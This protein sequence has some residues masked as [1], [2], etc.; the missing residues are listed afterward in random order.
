[1]AKK[2]TAWY[3]RRYVERFHFSLVPIEPG[4]KFPKVDDWGKN[5]LSDPDQA[6]QFYDD[7]AD[8]NIGVALGPSNL[9]S[10][11]VDHLESFK[12]ICECCGVDFDAL[13]A[14]TPTVRGRNPRLMF[15]V[16]AGANLPYRKLNWPNERDPDGSIHKDLIELAQQAKKD[17]DQKLEAQLREEAKQYAIYTVFELRSATDGKQRQDVLPP[18]IHPDTGNPYEW[19]TQPMDDW[20]EPPAWLL[21]IWTDW[22]KFKPQLRAMCPWSVEPEIPERKVKP[23]S[24]MPTTGV[25]DAFNRAN[26]LEAMLPHYGYKQIGKRWLSPHS[27]TSI[28]GVV[29]F[30]GGETCWIHHASDPLCSDE[31]GHPVGP[32]DLFCFYEHNGDVRRAVKAAADE[33]GMKP[34]AIVHNAQPLSTLTVDQETGEIILPP[35]GQPSYAE[36][37]A[38]AIPSRDTM[39]PLPWANDKGKPLKHIDNLREICNRL[40]VTIRYN[41]IK[42]EQELI[43]PGEKFSIDNEANAALA[44]LTSECS[45]FQFPTDKLGD[46]ITYLADQ[47]Q[48]NPV[49]RWITSKPWDGQDR[50]L[51]LLD[52][53]VA[54]DQDVNP[55]AKQLKE[56]LIL[57]WA[58]SAVAAAFSTNGISAPGILVFQGP[59]Y[60]GKTKWFKTLVPKDLD[61]LKDGMLLRPDDKDSVKQ[62]V[63]F[64]MVE[65]G[66]LDSTFRKSDIAALKAFI[67]NDRDILRRAYDRR[68]SQFA[69]RTVFFGSVNPREYLH[70][71]TGNRRYW[72]IECE[73]LDY[74]HTI[75]M[76]QFWAQIYQLWSDGEG[77]Y[78]TPEEMHLLNSHNDTFM[79][80][81]P[82]EERLDQSLDWDAPTLSWRWA[83][84]TILALECGIDRPSK[85]DLVAVSGYIRKRN[86]GQHKR[87][88]GKN[89]LFVPPSRRHH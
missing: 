5:A 34:P 80:L 74:N 73:S 58:I 88:N 24:N 36:D 76:Q 11:D 56:T 32:F 79:T 69:R 65:L 38:L 44:W 20:P 17:G 18:S 70:D 25:I 68:E 1:M 59:Q 85:S 28:P 71:P 51:Q 43:I 37:R 81:D 35:P 83:Q 40:G 7:H 33:L 50:I 77:F 49:T 27:S 31:S 61:L 46:F 52:T 64:W 55:S 23:R 87:S 3:A 26:D 14:A 21:A 86:G 62:C 42:K 84:A 4:R 54:R 75:D 39:S 67:T 82:V 72:T 45:L 8:W 16:P 60:I 66:E 19:I 89:L 78:L 30:P 57:R 22:D 48:F 6:E 63:S 13:V 15:R 41:V 29:L 2:P 47:N 9:A 10:L 12:L 53:V